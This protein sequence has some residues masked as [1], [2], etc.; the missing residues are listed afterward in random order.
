MKKD[1]TESVQTSGP[2]RDRLKGRTPRPVV[3]KPITEGVSPTT[4]PG[5][6]T[7]EKKTDE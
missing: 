5:D 1:K 7:E 6:E 2:L 3:E 4:F